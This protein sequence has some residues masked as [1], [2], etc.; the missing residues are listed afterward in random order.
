M[1]MAPRGGGAHPVVELEYAFDRLLSLKLEQAYQ[2][3]VPEQAR[4]TGAGARFKDEQD[5]D[6]RDLRPSVLGSAEGG[7]HDCQLDS[8]TERVRCRPRVRGT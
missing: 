1:A 5:E 3:L 4:A 8:G 6:G 2:I 7:Q